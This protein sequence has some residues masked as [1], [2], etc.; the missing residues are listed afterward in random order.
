MSGG[1]QVLS[2]EALEKAKR[3]LNED[4]ATRQVHLDKLRE[5]FNSRP[6]IKFRSD[7][8][9]LLRYLRCKKF[10]AERAFK[11]LVHYYEV[12]KE[13]KDIYSD[14]V[15][16]S[17]E[18]TMKKGIHYMSTGRDN[19]GRR[20]FIM[21]PGWM[22]PGT[23]NVVLM[24]RAL[25]LLMEKILEEE[26]TQINGIVVIVDLS[27]LTLSHVTTLG[28]S[29]ARRIAD[30]M[31]NALPLRLKAV[32]YV[33]QPK[34]FD[35]AFALFKP[36]FTE[37]LK[38]RLQFHGDEFDK[39]HQHVPSH[40]LPSEYGGTVPE[41]DNK[42]WREAMLASEQD[43]IENNK[44]GFPKSSDSLGGSSEGQDPNTGLKGSFKKLEI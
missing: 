22:E 38:K 37:K 41:F 1:K 27:N 12:R 26:E 20:V 32:H 23:T 18:E 25:V 4:P 8:A 31:Q 34:I 9:F 2:A 21:K 29:N 10:N 17:V 24:I 28:P 7:D 19:D 42:H 33:N 35:T 15:P 3:E 39:L 16:S 30:V 14:F 40:L 5:M 44:Y 6:D 13:F 43:Y 36:F 11:T